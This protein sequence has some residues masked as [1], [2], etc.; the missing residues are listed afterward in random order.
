M[1]MSRRFIGWATATALFTAL[2]CPLLFAAAQDTNATTHDTTTAGATATASTTF[3]TGG[4]TTTGTTGTPTTPDGE[5]SPPPLTAEEFDAWLVEEGFP[6]SYHAALRELHEQYPYWVFRAQHTGLSWQEVLDAESTVGVSLIPANSIGSWKSCEPNAFDPATGKWKG[7]DSDAWIAADRKIVA[8]CLDPRNAL[9]ATS[10]FQFE[11]LAY[12]DTCTIE[13]VRAILAGTFMAEGDWAQWFMDA[14][15]ETGVSPYHLASRAR[16]E[17]GAHG[18][19]LGHGTAAAPYAGYY[20]VFNI[21]A[22]ATGTLSPIQNG[23]R[24]A[25]TTN[26]AYHLPWTSAELSVRGGAVILGSSYI[27][28]EQ[29]T[30]YLQKWDVTDGGNGYYRHQYMTNIFAP[31]SE[32]TTLSGAYTDEVKAGAMEFCIPVYEDMPKAV[33]EKPT[34]TGTNNNWLSSLTVTDHTLSPTFSTY[35]ATY[36]LTVPATVSTI[37]VNAAAF[38]DTATVSGAGAVLLQSGMNTVE[39]RVTAASGD[40]RVYTLL[41]YR[42]PSEAGDDTEVPTVES[43]IYRIEEV[44]RGVPLDTTVED[45]LKGFTLSDE[46]ASLIVVDKDGVPKS[47]I[48]GTGCALHVV[49]GDTLFAIHPIVIRGDTSGDGLISVV[50]LLQVQQHLLLVRPLTDHRMNAADVSGDDRIS[51]VDLLAVQQHL[52]GVRVIEQ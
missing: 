51:I 22:Y 20:N 33:C 41:V 13:G 12:S 9:S 48:V 30:L 35:T 52:L 18:N 47:G 49:R 27:N 6:E 45:F 43:E 7:L 2:C 16:Q 5:E 36:N 38:S 44:I 25:A 23:A 24:Y 14:G 32:A 1:I 50:D 29:N 21:N 17:Q 8:Y 26:A 10:I 19:A 40:V 28:R 4:T 11:N 31:T 42:T 15:R 46:T 34:S 3:K 39:L 37:R